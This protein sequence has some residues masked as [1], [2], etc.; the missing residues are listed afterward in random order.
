MGGSGP[1]ASL[2][3]LRRGCSAAASWGPGSRSVLP[4]WLLDV[5]QG[6]CSGPSGLVSCMLGIRMV[7]GVRMGGVMGWDSWLV[8]VVVLWGVAVSLLG[9]VMASRLGGEPLTSSPGPGAM[10][11]M[12]G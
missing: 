12:T 1:A 7:W 10:F 4:S 8:V 11:F 9:G 2:L 5:G 3:L 6:A